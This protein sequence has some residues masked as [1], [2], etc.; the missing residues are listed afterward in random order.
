MS[1]KLRA[2]Y[3]VHG[4]GGLDKAAGNAMPVRRNSSTVHAIST[5]DDKLVGNLGHRPEP[6][7]DHTQHHQWSLPLDISSTAL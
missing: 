2:T 7:T 6:R 5:L 3:L 1:V 4:H